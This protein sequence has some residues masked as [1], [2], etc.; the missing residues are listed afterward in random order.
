MIRRKLR[1]LAAA[2]AATVLAPPGVA[3][4]S[5]ALAPAA[6]TCA[7]KSKPAGKVL[8]GYW[9]NW[10]GAANG[11]HP[12][13]GWTPIT[14]SRIGAHGYN[15][16]NAAFP[17]IRSDGTA[18][19]EGRHGPGREGG[20]PGRDVRGQGVRADAAA[21]HRRRDGRHRPRLGRRR[22]PL[23]RDDRADPQ[24]VQLRRHRHRHRDRPGRQRRH[25]PALHVPG[26][27]DPRHRRRSGPYAVRLRPHHG[28]GDRLRHRRQRGLRVDLGRVPADHQEVRG[29][30]PP[31]VA[32]HAVL[33]RQHVRLLRRL[34]PGGHRAG[35]HRPD[36][37]PGQGPGHPG[38]DDPRPPTTSRSRVC[39]PSPARAA[40]TWR[41]PRSPRRGTTTTAPS[42]A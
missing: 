22:R 2:L 38:H 35:L 32:Q 25:Q 8:Q 17:V 3:T 15:V 5:A 21:L 11:V 13:F 18:L 14:D 30:R 26:Q 34:L 1:L 6:D 39:P 9:E 37:L 29:Q 27:P 10:D 36:R 23:R 31:V 7:V 41:R 40:A 19:W 12:P 4:A 42:R 33:Q 20:D 28:P 16:I 24:E